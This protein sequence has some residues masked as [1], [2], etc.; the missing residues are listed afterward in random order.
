VRILFGTPHRKVEPLGRNMETPGSHQRSPC[1]Y[2]RPHS[3]GI[4]GCRSTPPYQSYVPIRQRNLGPCTCKVTPASACAHVV[5]PKAMQCVAKHKH[6]RHSTT[7]YAENRKYGWRRLQSPCSFIKVGSE[8]QIKASDWNEEETEDLLCLCGEHLL[9]K[10]TDPATEISPM[11]IYRAIAENAISLL[12]ALAV[13][14]RVF[15]P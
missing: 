14:P 7:Q 2:P 8:R 12:S 4:V 15:W 13:M 5:G 10:A 6:N 1:L 11:L 3:I 9:R